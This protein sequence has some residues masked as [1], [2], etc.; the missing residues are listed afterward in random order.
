MPLRFFQCVN[1]PRNTMLG[2]VSLNRCMIAPGNHTYFNSLRD[3][4][5]FRRAPTRTGSDQRTHA[6][7]LYP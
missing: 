1:K 7:F 6:P 5:P 3:A 4:P 2:R